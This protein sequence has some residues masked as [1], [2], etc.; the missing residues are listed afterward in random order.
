MNELD[1]IR[2]QLTAERQHAAD[3]ARN[4]T[5]VGQAQID[6]LLFVLARFEERDRILTDVYHSRFPATDPARPPLDALFGGPGT[7]HEALAML[8]SA[9]SATAVVGDA[10]T[11]NI[12]G[13]NEFVTYLEGPWC[14]RRDAIDAL[15]QQNVRIADWRAIS[16]VDADSIV[17]ERA[18]YARAKAD[19]A[20]ADS[21]RPAP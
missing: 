18:L 6:Y 4:G 5:R 21:G 14:A 2:N 16:F 19:A 11:G 8:E 20:K 12:R 9:L 17:K 15:L 10:Q 3:I 7:S 1:L 13:W